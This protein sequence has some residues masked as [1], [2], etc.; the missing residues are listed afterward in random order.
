MRFLKRFLWVFKDDAGVNP[1][2]IL[3]R[4][5]EL[6]WVKF[7][8]ASV[9]NFERIQ[10]SILIRF[11]EESREDLYEKSERNPIKIQQKLCWTLKGFW[12]LKSRIQRLTSESR[13]ASDEKPEKILMRILIGYWWEKTRFLMKILRKFWRGFIRNLLKFF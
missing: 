10:M 3:M 9:D 6:I 12:T 5:L 2:S 7:R 13:D 11:C 4:I 1:E 8:K